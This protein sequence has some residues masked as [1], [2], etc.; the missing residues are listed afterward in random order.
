MPALTPVKLENFNLKKYAGITLKDKTVILLKSQK[1]ISSE[2]G[3][4]LITHDGLFVRACNIKYL[5]MR[6]KGRLSNNDW[7]QTDKRVLKL[8]SKY[9]KRSVKNI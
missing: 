5:K 7:K 3:D 8:A 9:P 1:E 6:Q 2:Y 4:I